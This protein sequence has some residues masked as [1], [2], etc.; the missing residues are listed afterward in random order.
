MAEE[1]GIAPRDPLMATLVARIVIFI[2]HFR[3]LTSLSIESQAPGAYTRDTQ[4]HYIL[5]GNAYCVC[6][7][8]HT[9][10]PL[11]EFGT[12]ESKAARATEHMG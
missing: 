10:T 5:H 11:R 4:G 6:V 9:K 8:K 7:S 12:P 2:R 3:H 1:L